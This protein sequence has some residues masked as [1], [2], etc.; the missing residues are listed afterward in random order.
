MRTQRRMMAA[1]VLAITLSACAPASPPATQSVTVD[2]FFAH[3][4]PTRVTLISE[5]HTIEVVDDVIAGVLSALVA[6][7]VQPLDADYENLWGAGSAVLSTSRSADVLTVDLSVAPLSLGAEAE[8]IALAQLVWTATS[9]DTS[10]S[11]VLVTIDGAGAETLAGHV[12]IT[13]PIAR[14]RA[15]SVLSPLQILAPEEG[16]AVSNP[17][18]AAG[19]ACTFEASYSWTL[20][21]PSGVVD[22]GFGMASEGCPTRAPWQLELGSLSAGDYVLTV[23]ELSA[24]DG[25]VWAADSKS[26]TVTK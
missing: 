8:S 5:P 22:E 19:M 13:R 15:E 4:Q 3:A 9:I 16:S 6:G 14:D 24:D 10:L 1:A 12:D 26:F 7:E 20:E 11:A 25:S 18:V 23:F 2:V 21:G 17:V